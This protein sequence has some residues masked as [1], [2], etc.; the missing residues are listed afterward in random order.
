MFFFQSVS[1]V[2][3]IAHMLLTAAVVAVPVYFQLRCLVMRCMP[4]M[5]P[6]GCDERSELLQKLNVW[7]SAQSRSALPFSRHD[8]DVLRLIGQ[9]VTDLDGQLAI[10]STAPTAITAKESVAVF[11]ERLDVVQKQYVLRDKCLL[12]KV[13]VVMTYVL[14]MYLVHAIPEFTR[15]TF[16]WVIFTGALLLIVLCNNGDQ[17]PQLLHQIE[18]STLLFVA[19]VFVMMEGVRLLGLFERIAET[20]EHHV[21]TTDL[22]KDGQMCM[23]IFVIIW[24]GI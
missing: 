18:W 12:I 4:N 14:V 13:C 24:V 23:A 16:G 15:M 7:R 8:D 22:S 10:R 21:L 2:K 6:Y 17:L 9:K 11:E 3:F 20:L 19:A 5:R 1:I